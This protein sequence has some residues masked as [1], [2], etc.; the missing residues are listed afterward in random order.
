MITVNEYKDLNKFD[1]MVP[2][3]VVLVLEPKEHEWVKLND[4]WYNI[5]PEITDG[6]FKVD[7]IY[8]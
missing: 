7:F 4:G 1:N 8:E 2:G 5:N 6:V 3:T